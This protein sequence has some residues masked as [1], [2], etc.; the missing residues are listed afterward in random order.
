MV[1][2]LL[3][4]ATKLSQPTIPPIPSRRFYMN[5]P[6]LLATACAEHF[7][8]CYDAHSWKNLGS[9][10]YPSTV[11]AA[12]IWMQ[13][14][15]HY[16]YILC[17]SRCFLVANLSGACIPVVE[18]CFSLKERS[19]SGCIPVCMLLKISSAYYLTY[20]FQVTPV[21]WKD[22]TLVHSAICNLYLWCV[23][24]LIHLSL[25]C[26]ELGMLLYIS[27]SQF[28]TICLRSSLDINFL[29]YLFP[30]DLKPK[31]T[32]V[33]KYTLQVGLQCLSL[34]TLKFCIICLFMGP[35]LITQCHFYNDWTFMKCN[36]ALLA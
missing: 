4:L 36:C 8:L 5:P 18:P 15:V 1:L 19:V 9:N 12:C 23:F 26:T 33:V 17:V 29:K 14:S 6:R 25:F 32:A 11:A 30:K 28:V 34:Q 35:M 20:V 10:S 16:C 24:T 22:G 27:A 3:R 31:A 13:Y 21:I 2:L 7:V